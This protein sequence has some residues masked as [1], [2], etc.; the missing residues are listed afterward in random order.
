MY[1]AH[2]FVLI[3][4]VT[5]AFT[6]CVC[7]RTRVCVNICPLVCVSAK[8][9]GCSRTAKKNLYDELMIIADFS[10]E[11]RL[12]CHGANCDYCIFTTEQILSKCRSRL[13]GHLRYSRGDGVARGGRTL[14]RL[15]LNSHGEHLAQPVAGLLLSSP[16]RDQAA[17]QHEAP[18]SSRWT[19]RCGR[20]KGCV[21]R[22]HRETER[23][24]PTHI[25]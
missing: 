8:P 19:P 25:T 10:C 12:T 7:A 20:C 17:E 24:V 11:W 23:N 15:L 22:M 21:S 4:P 13:K 5:G 18:S 6:V 3:P 9:L 14:Q 16:E 2:C 1:T